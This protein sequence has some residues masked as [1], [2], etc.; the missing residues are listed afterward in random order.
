MAIRVGVNYVAVLFGIQLPLT[1]KLPLTRKPYNKVT[2][3]FFLKKSSL[4]FYYC[5]KM[6]SA[7]IYVYMSMYMHVSIQHKKNFVS[8]CAWR[9]LMNNMHQGSPLALWL[10]YWTATLDCKRVR[11]PGAY[12][13]FPTN[14]G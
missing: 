9:T 7:C 11:I 3:I 1:V 5:V 4:V 14:W 12:V 10:T 8:I 2:G 13:H 6:Y